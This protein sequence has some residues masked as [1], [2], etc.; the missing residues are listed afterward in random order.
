MYISEI[1]RRILNAVESKPHELVLH[2]VCDN[3]ANRNEMTDN[4]HIALW[5]EGAPVTVKNKFI[6]LASG[7][8]GDCGLRVCSKCGR[9]MKEGYLLHGCDL[10]ACTESCAIQLYQEDYRE[11][12]GM[13][14]SPAEARRDLVYDL[15]HYPDDNFWTEWVQG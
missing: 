1:Q 13:N 3:G 8:F 6:D 4:Y 15:E 10:Y 2:F 12:Y 14:Q 5:L 11:R 9:F 7:L